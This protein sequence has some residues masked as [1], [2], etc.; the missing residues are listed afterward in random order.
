[1]SSE[2]LE[3]KINGKIR[4]VHK[5]SRGGEYYIKNKREKNRADL[6]LL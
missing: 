5:G 4:V 6:F 1:M 3:K 2:E